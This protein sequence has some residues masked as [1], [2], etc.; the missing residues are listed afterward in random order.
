MPRFV[1]SSS[2]Q[3]AARLVADLR[4][5]SWAQSCFLMQLVLPPTPLY[6]FSPTTLS[7]QVAEARSIVGARIMSRV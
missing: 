3:T 1:E 7:T 2:S 5:Q 6:A 4:R